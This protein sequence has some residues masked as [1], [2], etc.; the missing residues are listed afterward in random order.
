MSIGSGALVQELRLDVGF[1][2]GQGIEKGVTPHFLRHTAATLLL[3]TGRN[4]REVQGFL[5]HANIVTTQVYTHVLAEGLVAELPNRPAVPAEDL[6]V[7]PVVAVPDDAAVIEADHVNPR[8][9]R[10]LHRGRSVPRCRCY[11]SIGSTWR[12]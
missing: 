6:P 8:A 10:D 11:V 12:Q 2:E 3:K 9:D 7:G 5:G 4:L 1:R